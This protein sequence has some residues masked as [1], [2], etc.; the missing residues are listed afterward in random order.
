MK[1]GVSTYSFNQ[2][3]TLQLAEKKPVDYFMLCDKA[4][5]LGFEGIEFVGL[6]WHGL[7]TDELETAKA[8]K[9]YCAK[10]NLEIIAYTVG[11]NFLAEDIRTE[12]ERLKKCVDVAEALGA[13]LMRHDV[14][15]ELKKQPLY[16]Y[17][18]AIQEIVPYIR[19]LT[20]YAKTKGIRTCTENHGYVMQDPARVEELIL[21]VNHENYGWLCDIGNFLCADADPARS[22]AIA[23]PYA[24][25][26]HA[27]DFLVKS[28]V[29][30]MP[31]GYII[32]TNAGNYLRGTVI[33]HGEV[34]I[35]NCINA[36]KKSGYSGWISIE[37]EGA[38]ENIEALKNGLANLKFFIE[39][40]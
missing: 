38:E 36:L 33:G 16:N 19:E 25:H 17:R 35:G 5:E 37:F 24:F 4:K 23:A 21:A 10:I 32:T 39:E 30:K 18:T 29:E 15:Y 8:I 27:K 20:E 22:T 12:I 40:R 26:V 3:V 7:C 1:I 6:D 13:P 2:F 34:P 14:F 11:A 9:E 28:G 31:T